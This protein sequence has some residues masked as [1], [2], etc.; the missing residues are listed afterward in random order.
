[1]TLASRN[2]VRLL[3]RRPLSIMSLTDQDSAEGP[4]KFV[5]T[6]TAN[7]TAE[8]IGDVLR[9]WL[10]RLGLESARVEFSGYNQVF[11]EL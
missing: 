10:S 4:P 2:P 11:Q 7:F 8:P 6:V 3:K 5:V 1:M 9:F